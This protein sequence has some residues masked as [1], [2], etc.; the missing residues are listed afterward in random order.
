LGLLILAKD[1]KGWH[2]LEPGMSGRPLPAKLAAEIEGLQE[3]H[4]IAIEGGQ[5][6]G[7]RALLAALGWP[8]GWVIRWQLRVGAVGVVARHPPPGFDWEKLVPA[9]LTA[10]Y[11]WKDFQLRIGSALAKTLKRLNQ[12]SMYKLPLPDMV[13]EAVAL[14]CREMGLESSVQWQELHRPP[15]IPWAGVVLPVFRSGSLEGWV[16]VDLGIR[17]PQLSAPL[18]ELIEACEAALEREA[19]FKELE[20]RHRALSALVEVDNALVGVESFEGLSARIC[21]ILGQVIGASAVSFRQLPSGSTFGIGRFGQGGQLLEVPVVVKG[22]LTG[23]MW[24]EKPAGLRFSRHDIALCQVV[25]GRV[26]AALER[27]TLFRQVARAKREWEQTFDA[28]GDAIF[29][30]DDQGVLIRANRSFA[31]LYGVPPQKV[32]SRSLPDL[33]R[34][35][36]CLRRRL[37]GDS[38]PEGQ[39]HFAQGIWGLPPG[40]TEELSFGERYFEMSKYAL[41]LQDGQAGWVAIMKDVTGQRTLQEAVLRS[42]KL[43]V[44]GEMASGIAHDFNNLL[45]TVLGRTEMLLMSSMDRTLKEEVRS[46]QQAALDGREMVRRI[47]EYTRIRRDSQFQPVDINDCVQVAVDLAKPRWRDAAYAK[48]VKI[49]VHM[50]L[51][52]V[53]PVMGSASD[54]REVILNLVFNAIDAM[55]SGGDLYVATWSD[56]RK[57]HVAVRDS[58]VGMSEEVKRRIFDPFFTTKGPAGSG[59]GLSIAWGIVTRHG[60]EIRVESQPRKGSTFTVVLPAAPEGSRDV[61]S[62]VASSLPSPK[63]ILLVDEDRAVAGSTA[64]LLIKLGHEVTVTYNGHEAI[65]RLTAGDFDLVISDLGMPEMDGWEVA[66]AVKAVKPWVPVI[67][68]TGWAFEIEEADARNQGVDAVLRK[69]FSL[70]EILRAIA[71]VTE[72]PMGEPMRSGGRVLVVDD[73]ASVGEALAALLQLEGLEPKVVHGYHEALEALG[74]FVPDAAFVDVVLAD[75]DGMELASCIKKQVP[76]VKVVMMSGY[77]V[78]PDDP[79]FL[80]GPVDRVLPKPWSQGELEAVVRGLFGKLRRTGDSAT[81]EA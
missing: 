53:P 39:C 47:Q 19:L 70:D 67:L 78:V 59:L 40:E 65:R 48:G 9:A 66:R 32:V 44:L 30:L 13:S 38:S 46:I 61:Q 57:V 27:S 7:F 36:G 28:I 69:P 11:H 50:D 8:K 24:V 75:G 43:R 5:L 33:C 21:H 80:S 10:A 81:V 2:I 25:A 26:A 29:L 42:E 58:G 73:E 63:K 54:L 52:P 56:G 35:Y 18:H 64:G 41:D 6:Q 45:S 74:R 51:K 62:S 3:A 72:R 76:G 71:T 22:R 34:L 4:P 31:S 20:E 15:E 77:A 14:F 23:R 60:G 55:P 37:G 12:S 68:A 49:N 17:D 16:K 1:D 79:Q